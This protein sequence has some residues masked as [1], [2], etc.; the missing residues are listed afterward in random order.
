MQFE[1]MSRRDAVKYTKR[2]HKESSIIIS[3]SD[4]YDFFPNFDN[5]HDNG[6]KSILNLSFDDVQELTGES[7]RYLKKD[8]GIIFDNLTGVSYNLIS[9]DDAT[10]IVNFVLAWKDKVDKIIVHC[11]AGISRSSGVCAAIMKALTGSDKE[12]FNNPRYY[13]NT[14]CYKKVLEEFVKRGF[15]CD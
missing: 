8:E 3:I 1:V 2:E 10:K 15:Y 5:R 6:V 13:P 12:I 9:K 11:N 14:T 7:K 4:S